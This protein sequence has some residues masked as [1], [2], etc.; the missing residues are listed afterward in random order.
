LRDEAAAHRPA[1]RQDALMGAASRGS[2]LHVLRAS[3]ALVVCLLAEGAAAEDLPR[4]RLV[5]RV[6]CLSNPQQG[7][8]LY[9]PSAYTADRRWPLLV[10][11]DPRARGAVPVTRFLDEA[12]R[13]GV[14]V[15]GSNT[16]RN[17]P[18]GVS[19]GVLLTLLNDLTSRFAIDPARVYLAGFSGGARVATLAALELDG[20]IA[21]VIA[22]GA[23]FPGGSRPSAPFRFAFL[24]LAG[25]D[26]FNYPELTDLDRRLDTLGVVHALHLFDG[27]HDWPPPEVCA[28]GLAWM[29]V[30]AMR[31]GIRPRDEAL[32]DAVLARETSAAAA[33]EQAGHL[34]RA[35]ERYR[36]ASNL[37]TGLRDVSALERKARESANSPEARR[38]RKEEERSIDRQR[39]AEAELAGLV[40]EA[41]SGEDGPAAISRLLATLASLRARSERPTNDGA[42]MAARRAVASSWVGLHE[43]VAADLQAGELDRAASR[44]NLMRLIRPADP[45]VEVLLTRALARSGR[46]KDALDAFRRAIDKGFADAAAVDAEPDFES[47]RGNAAFERLAARLKRRP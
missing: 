41:L 43:A 42:R 8:A 7:F 1:P 4:G 38:S 19:E 44:L 9:L 14:V 15:A 32:L 20:R 31:R 27:R 45:G 33:E 21:G 6:Q 34:L 11:L 23:G 36:S 25:T 17:G 16:S 40:G 47:L 35:A 5:E 37:L 13:L 22:A 29:E 46:K 28:R 39:A 10:A 2:S 12:E 24:G 3:A 26:D 30:Q 18:I